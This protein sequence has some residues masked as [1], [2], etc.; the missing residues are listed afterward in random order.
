MNQ[1]PMA[2]IVMESVW[3]AWWVSWL[4]AAFWSDRPVD[5]PPGSNQIIY[6]LLA[7]A[8]VLLLFGVYRPGWP[9]DVLLW[10]VP[11]PL[12][13]AMIAAAAGGFAFTWWARIHLGRLWSSGVTQK[14]DHRII[15]TGPYGIVRH[16]IYTGITLA[17]FATA[18]LRGT[19]LA[20]AGAAVMTLG[21]YVKARLEEQF[22]RAQLGADQ[23]ASYA[24]RVP[25]LVPSI[26]GR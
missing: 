13:T 4:A 7:I 9:R 16:P 3:G 19:M 17:A 26:W 15:D 8:G 25:M 22:L 6:R 14:S 21:W 1:T 24:R 2:I 23:Y 11:L 20:F 18:I 12:Q 5:R 10:H